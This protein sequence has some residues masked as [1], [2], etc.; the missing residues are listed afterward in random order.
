MSFPKTVLFMALSL[1]LSFQ[2]LADT[3]QKTFKDEYQDSEYLQYPS[4]E[5]ERAK[6]VSVKEKQYKYILREDPSSSDETTR[7]ST[8]ERVKKM[9]QLLTLIALRAMRGSAEP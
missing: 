9:K 1:L 7:S 4:G 6:T 2:C 5:R 3:K 8:T